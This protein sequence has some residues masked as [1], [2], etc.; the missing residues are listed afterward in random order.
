[1]SRLRMR[2]WKGSAEPATGTLPV[3]KPAP[4]A[5]CQPLSSSP[6]FT[7]SSC[8]ALEAEPRPPPLLTSEQPGWSGRGA[9]QLST[10]LGL[11]LHEGESIRPQLPCYLPVSLGPK[12]VRFSHVG[13]RPGCHDMGC[14]DRSWGKWPRP[15]LGPRLPLAS[16]QPGPPCGFSQGLSPLS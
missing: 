14:H 15:S 10:A 5:C 7:P 16:E 11:A 13:H 4:P 9:T 2:N 1:M 8:R 3:P 12:G 6:S